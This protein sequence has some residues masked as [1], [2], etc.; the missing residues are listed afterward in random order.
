M[1]WNLQDQDP[2]YIE[3]FALQ[4]TVCYGSLSQLYVYMYLCMYVM[5]CL[6]HEQPCC[7]KQGCNEGDRGAPPFFWGVREVLEVKSYFYSF[8]RLWVLTFLY[9]TLKIWSSTFIKIISKGVCHCP[10]FYL[11]SNFNKCRGKCHSG[12]FLKS[13]YF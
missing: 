1:Q 13:L 2:P 8:W 3:T 5:W 9:L 4:I 7:I 12:A 11:H 6:P 10:V